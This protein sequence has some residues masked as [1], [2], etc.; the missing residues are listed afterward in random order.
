VALSSQ[1]QSS[2]SRLD[3]DNDSRRCSCCCI[4]SKRNTINDVETGIEHIENLNSESKSIE[5]YLIS[6]NFCIQA[7]TS[8]GDSLLDVD[9]ELFV[10]S[11]ITGRRDFNLLFWARGKN[12]ICKMI[13]ILYRNKIIY[14]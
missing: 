4:R 6:S 1:N 3:L 2:H 10:W 5:F 12:K 8:H 9:K 11:V 14:L 13:S 7:L